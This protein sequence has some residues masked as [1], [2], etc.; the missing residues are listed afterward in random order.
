MYTGIIF[1]NFGFALRVYWHFSFFVIFNFL[2]IF[3]FPECMSI[4]LFG[5]QKKMLDLLGL[6]FRDSRE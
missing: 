6:E 2:C 1:N 3:V 4:Y 5:G